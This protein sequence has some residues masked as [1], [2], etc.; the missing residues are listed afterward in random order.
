MK[1]ETSEHSPFWKV[2]YHEIPVAIN[3]ED[4]VPETPEQQRQNNVLEVG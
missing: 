1:V 4:V 2:F 3:V